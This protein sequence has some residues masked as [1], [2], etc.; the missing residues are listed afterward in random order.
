MKKLLYVL[1]GIIIVVVLGIV[2]LVTLVNPNQF[3]PVIAEQVKEQTG[4]DLVISGDIGWRFFPTL[5]IEYWRNRT[6]APTRFRTTEF[7]PV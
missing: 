3:K 2:A 5:G 1:L 7:N 6:K 4:R